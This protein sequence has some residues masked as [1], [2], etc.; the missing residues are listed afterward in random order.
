MILDPTKTKSFEVWVDADFS[1]NWS[2]ST[3]ENDPSTA[4][5]RS[6]Y[7]ITYGGCP[8]IWVSKLQTQIALSS[9]EAEYISLSQSLR[10]AIPIMRM[11]Q[12]LKDRGFNDEYLKPEVRCKAF[13]D[14]TGAL[15][16]ATV[17][18]MRPRTKHI[19]LVYHHFREA[20]RD[21]LVTIISV[22]TKDQV[23]D[24]FTKPLPQNDFVK[25]RKLLMGW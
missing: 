1:G 23:G 15:T 5:S 21:G 20:V 25:F 7:V 22:G 12:E 6:G 13:E 16:L 19:N 9:C 10:D 24:M 11:L 3:A 2:K 17:P 18:K 8:I 4:K 14:N